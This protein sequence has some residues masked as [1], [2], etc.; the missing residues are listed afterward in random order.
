MKVR[1]STKPLSRVAPFLALL[2]S[3][4]GCQS[5][6]RTIAPPLAGLPSIAFAGNAFKGKIVFHSNRD[7]DYEIFAMNADGSG[8]TQL[9]HNDSNEFD[10]TW[11]PDGKRI[12]F[13][14]FP[15]DF[16]SDG[17]LFVMNA[18]GSG[19]TQ[20]TDNS[21]QDFG[22]IWS[23]DGKRLAFTSDRTGGS[24]VFSMNTDGSG[25]SQLTHGSSVNLA[26]N[27]SPDG[28]QI[29]FTAYADGGPSELFVMN[30]DGTGV[31][32]LTR[33]AFSDEGDHAGWSPDGKQLVFSSDRDGGDLDI[34]VMNADGTNVRQLTH[35]DFITDD[36]P[37]WSPDGTQIAFQSNGTGDEEI[38]VMN[39]DG[40]GV[41][42]ITNVPWANDAVAVWT[43]GHIAAP[44]L[45]QNFNQ[46]FDFTFTLFNPCNGEPIL[47]TGSYHMNGSVT[48]TSTSSENRFHLSTQD[49]QG[50]GQ[51]TGLKYVFHE[52]RQ[53]EDFFTFNPFTEKFESSDGYDV[54]SQG[55][56]ANFH[57]VF[58]FSFSYP[59][60]DFKIIRDTTR[61]IGNTG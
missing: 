57:T 60:G 50:V 14:S 54:I 33:N 5:T 38:Y 49:F 30:A 15:N 26:T 1:M 44:P 35:N 2:F 22:P 37:Y 52:Q 21:A 10:P 8:Q 3:L 43:S 47:L 7:G 31:V 36:D 25:V 9:T 19:L 34:F 27:W 45:V 40:S 11:S 23:P 51:T 56:T 53:S 20:I 6:D 16:S 24:E 13:T 32:Q 42:R 39:V 48:T 55:S 12:A 29:A 46:N 61:C 41:T 4:V 18:D 28:R 17:E 59:P 58:A